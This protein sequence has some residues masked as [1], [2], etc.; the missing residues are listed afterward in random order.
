MLSLSRLGAIVLLFAPLRVPP[1]GEAGVPGA[2]SAAA[3]DDEAARS[4][5]S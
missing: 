5:A 4:D 1:A 3:A 2:E